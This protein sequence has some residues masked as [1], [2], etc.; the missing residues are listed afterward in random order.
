MESFIA[1]ATALIS[2]ASI[3]AAVTP[4]QADD[5]LL[6]KVMTVVNALACNWGS[7]KNRD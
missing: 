5:N 2:A 6:R 4:T 1:W 3:I 7:A